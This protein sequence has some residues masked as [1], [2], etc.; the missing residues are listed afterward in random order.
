MEWRKFKIVWIGTVELK[1]AL[2]LIRIVWHGLCS[3]YET[4]LISFLDLI[5]WFLLFFWWRFVSIN[6]VRADILSIGLYR[7]YLNDCVSLKLNLVKVCDVFLCVAA[8]KIRSYFTSKKERA[9]EM[10]FFPLSLII[11]DCVLNVLKKLSD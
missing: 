8:Y 2:A 4:C 3:V 6:V 7:L 5:N 9:Y 11:L 1:L 10:V